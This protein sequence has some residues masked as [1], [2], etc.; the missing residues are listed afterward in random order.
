[1]R[2]VKTALALII[3]MLGALASGPGLAAGHGGHGGSGFRGGGG[4]HSGGGFHGGGFHRG[5]FRGGA[6]FGVFVGAPL[7]WPGYYYGAPYYYPPYYADPYYYPPAVAMESA[8]PV[9]E[10]QGGAQPLPAPA[11]QSQQNWWYYCA[12]SKMYY[13]YV[14]ECPGGWQRVAPQPPAG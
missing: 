10:E 2:L 6:R 9:Y 7:F 14:R 3:M 13:P 8:P 1:M 12:D 4:F 5:G 11:P